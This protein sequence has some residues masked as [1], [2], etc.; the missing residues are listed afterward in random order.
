MKQT[1]ADISKIVESLKHHGI[2]GMR[3]GIRRDPGADGRVETTGAE[4]ARAVELLRKRNVSS[5]SNAELKTL[6]T[7]LQ[8]EKQFSDLNRKEIS[9]GRKFVNEVVGN[10]VKTVATEYIMKFLKESATKLVARKAAGS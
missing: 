4:D 5:L 1:D 2:L 3:W 6:T 8:L 9:A 10:A 7:R